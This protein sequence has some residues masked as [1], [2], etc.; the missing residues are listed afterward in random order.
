M[1]APTRAP[2]NGFNAWARRVYNP[3]GFSKAYNFILWFIF[4][5]AL[6]GFSLS[7]FMYLDFNRYFCPTNPQAGIST[8]PGECYYYNT[9]TRDK[10]GIMLHLGGILPASLL[11]CVQFT[12][13]IRHKWIIIHRI[14]G[15]LAVLLYIVSLAGALMIAHMAF[16]GGLDVQVWVGFVGI[17]VFVCFVLS[18]VNVK[19]LQ[20]EQHRAWMLR[21]W[22]YVSVHYHLAV[23][24][25]TDYVQAGSIITTRFIMIISATIISNKGHY[26]VWSCAKIA[27]TISGNMDLVS[28]YPACA[29]YADGSNLNQVS[30]VLADMDG[31]SAANAGAALNVNF[32]MALWLASAI[33]AI[34]VEV[35]VSPIL[36]CNEDL[37]LTYLQLRL[38]PREAERLRQ[39]S[40]TRQLEAGMH[41]P[42][43]AG[44]TA[45]RLGDA[46]PW[47]A[48]ER[49]ASNDSLVVMLEEDEATK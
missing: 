37:S 30:A 38:T 23:P 11:V 24:C 5:G 12:P 40:Y 26:A 18:I 22:F 32:G 31:A 35:Y 36:S 46:K 14:S 43:S 44:L 3:L 25:D 41:N 15:Y 27:A 17:G 47:I 8:A 7:R 34:G 16:G 39:V 28:A 49:R 21:G 29:S 1:A 9:F 20:I 10:I 42:G 4:A 13:F 19:R 6:F 45:D 48:E 33:H 2:R